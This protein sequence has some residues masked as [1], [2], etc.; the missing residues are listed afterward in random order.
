MLDKASRSIADVMPPNCKQCGPNV[1]LLGRL[2]EG[3]R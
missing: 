3:A 2:N 1:V